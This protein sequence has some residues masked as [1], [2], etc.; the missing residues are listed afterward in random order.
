M[1]KIFY[2]L[3]ALSLFSCS[4]NEEIIEETQKQDLQP[5]KA[6]IHY[7]DRPASNLNA[8]WYYRFNYENGNLTKI[9]GW[10]KGKLFSSDSYTYLTYQGNEVKVSYSFDSDLTNVYTLQNNKPIK[11][12]LY[13]QDYIQGTKTYAYENDKIKIYIKLPN[14]LSDYFLTYYFN[15][16]TKNLIKSEFLHQSQGTDVEL[17][18]IVY[19]DFDN[20]QNP[21]KKMGL[22]SDDLY[23]KSLSANNFRTKMVT[24]EEFAHP[25]N[26]N[27]AMPPS[28]TIQNLTYKYDSNGQVLLYH[29]L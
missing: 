3:F 14:T 17:T 5:D 23:E 18:T 27:V 1:K 9:S 7:V 25:L 26:G 13:I 2:I 29:P 20:A 16:V 19:S 21:F 15:P 28:T 11:E 10:L 12:V 6:Y 4:S 22:V 8:D 24:V